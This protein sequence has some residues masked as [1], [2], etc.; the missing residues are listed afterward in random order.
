MEAFAKA[1]AAILV[2]AGG[3]C[4]ASLF[5]SGFPAPDTHQHF[6]ADKVAIHPDHLAENVA[7][8]RPVK[9]ACVRVVEVAN[10]VAG[11]DHVRSGLVVAYLTQDLITLSVLGKCGVLG[12]GRTYIVRLEVLWPY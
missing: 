11:M 12:S 1:G 6:E 7:S 5:G 10:D 4:A 8:V 2:K 3:E 9:V